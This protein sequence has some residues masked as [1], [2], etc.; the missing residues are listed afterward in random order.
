MPTSHPANDGVPAMRRRLAWFAAGLLALGGCQQTGPKQTFPAELPGGKPPSSYRGPAAV[1]SGSNSSF[2]PT[3]RQPD[4]VAPKLA[5]APPAR[6]GAPRP[7]SPIVQVRLDG[8]AVYRAHPV[9]PA[10]P[11]SWGHAPD[12][13][14]LVGCLSCDEARGVVRLRYANTNEGD[15][16]GGCL[17]LIGVGVLPGFFPGQVVR[18]EGELINPAPNEIMPIYRVQTVELL[19]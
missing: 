19:Q 17:D 5:K 14:W 11:A 15:P 4:T 6:L 8:I 1:S 10:R 7:A 9:Q 2:S 18:V 3:L 16:H 13:S 12:Y